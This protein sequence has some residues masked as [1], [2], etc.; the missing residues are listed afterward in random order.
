MQDNKHRTFMLSLALGLAMPL[1]VLADDAVEES[2][3]A[4]A[5]ATYVWQAKPSF[6]AP[7]TGAFS[8]R[9]EREKSYSFSAT[10]AFGWRAWRGSEL[11]LDPELLQ[12]VPLSGLTGLG[13]MANAELAKSSGPNPTLYRARLFLRQAW[14]LGGEK[15]TVE[16]DMNQLAGT[17]DKRRIVLTAG[18]SSVMD[19]FDNSA[20]AHDTRTQFMNAALTTHGAW[21]FPADARGY[22]WGAAVE[23][24]RDDWVLRAGRFMQ[25]AE[26]NGLPLDKRI[27]RHYGDQVELEHVHSVG[28][29]PGKL[30]VLAFRNRA[31]MGRFRDAL[32]LAATDGTTPDVSRV[33]TGHVKYGFGLG[34]EQNLASD[35]AV[36]GRVA[37]NDGATETYAFTEI[38]RSL[39]AGMAA[40]GSA[41]ARAEDTF[42][43]AIARNGL[44]NAHRDYLAAGGHGA[45]IGDGK[46]QYGA[47]QIVELYYSAKVAAHAW[48]SLDAQRIVNPAYNTDRGPVTVAGIRLHAAY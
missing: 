16:S 13:G 34:G 33:R 47:E 38:E 1:P 21:D 30:R 45:F 9:P 25:P 44:S 26:S 28:D 2:W 5:Q 20:Y 31:V 39:S 29:Q 12:G 32:D 6:S 17:V 48:M 14:N 46:L 7:Y 35:I 10:A 11:Y 22:T 18:N 40:K 27:F 19:V 24:Y 42:G 36:F 8:L 43:M 3:N 23:Y 4:H 37:W 15:E 41:W